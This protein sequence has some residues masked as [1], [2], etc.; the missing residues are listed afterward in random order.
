MTYSLLSK[1]G[2]LAHS[3]PT[4][5]FSA[6]VGAAASLGAGCET[7]FSLL[8]FSVCSLGTL[9]G[10]EDGGSILGFGLSSLTGLAVELQEISI[11]LQLL[12]KYKRNAKGKIQ[13]FTVNLDRHSSITTIIIN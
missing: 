5:L 9:G 11:N 4:T 8:W 1:L 3:H 6:L 7:A 2:Q 10:W 13:D 12:V